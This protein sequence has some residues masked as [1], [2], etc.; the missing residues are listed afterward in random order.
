MAIPFL[1]SINMNKNEIQNAV[2]QNLATAPANPKT[3]QYYYNTTDSKMYQWTGKEWRVVGVLVINNLTSS[4]TG[5]ALSAAQGKEL[6]RLIDAINTDME[7]K[8]A[9]DMLKSVYDTNGNGKVDTAENADKV[10]GHTVAVDVPSGAK[11]TDTIY[12]HPAH[13]AKA[14]GLYKVTVDAQ[15][16]VSA[17]TAVTK[18]DITNLGIPAQDTTYPVADGSNT[19]L[20]NASLYNQLQLALETAESADAQSNTNLA[21]IQALQKT[22]SNLPAEQFLDLT[23]TKFVNSFAWSTATYP[24][25]TNPSLEGKPVL[26]LALKDEKDNVKYSFLNMF[27]LVDQYTGDGTVV[28]SGNNISHKNS[29]ATAGSYGNSAN[30]T[31]AFGAT[32]NVPYITVDAKGHATA[33]S[34]KTVTIPNKLA[35]TTSNGLM[36]SADKT[37]VDSMKWVHRVVTGTLAA[38]KLSLTLDPSSQLDA[39]GT[40]HV[41]SVECFLD[42]T[43]PVMCDIEYIGG[44]G[45][46][47]SIA[48]AQDVAIECSLH[49]AVSLF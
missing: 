21:S 44:G 19:G 28:V 24:G 20:M 7:D 18:A 49:L 41:V 45:V 27:D 25:S 26:V 30:Q 11:F 43:T 5:S 36:T 39:G 1:T 35:S 3:G 29:G 14:S 47:I 9:G 15:G 12:T 33:V 22:V 37:K 16:H 42:G 31:P 6:K 48:E 32:F 13:S 38:G 34:N 46:T 4:D 10:N 40:A 8:G 23:K 17:V 2:M